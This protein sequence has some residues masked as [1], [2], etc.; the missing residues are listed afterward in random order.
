M[1][2]KLRGR[3]VFR[4]TNTPNLLKIE[5]ASANY[6]LVIDGLQIPFSVGQSGAIHIPSIVA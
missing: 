4:I 3:H 1:R 2:L 5:G 6:Y